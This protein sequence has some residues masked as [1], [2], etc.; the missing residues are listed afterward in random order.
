[1]TLIGENLTAQSMG[2]QTGIGGGYSNYRD[3]VASSPF[4]APPPDCP[5][6][7]AHRLIIIIITIIIITR[8]LILRYLVSK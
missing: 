4:P 1:M 6:E 2:S 3:V 8:H 5:E 7:V